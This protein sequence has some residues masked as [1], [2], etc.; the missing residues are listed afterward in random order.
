M[1]GSDTEKQQV[2]QLDIDKAQQ[3]MTRDNGGNTRL[4][5]L[6]LAITETVT[7]TDDDKDN[8]LWMDDNNSE[9]SD[10]G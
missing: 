3:G 5:G 8:L 4:Q 6:W 9:D 1:F 7:D 10:D 2:A